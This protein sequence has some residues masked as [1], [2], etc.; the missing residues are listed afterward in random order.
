[1]DIKKE[2]RTGILYSAMG[3]Y[4]NMLIQILLNS[5]LS[6]ILTPN[7]FGIVAVVNVFLIFFQML[8]DFGIGPAIIQH[9]SLSKNEI[10]Q[11]FSFLSSHSAAFAALYCI[12]IVKIPP[13]VQKNKGN[14]VK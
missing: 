10:Q 7:E 6:R 8:A 9:K 14:F 2:F 4:S 5:I 1:M 13:I 12:A 11:I 3:K